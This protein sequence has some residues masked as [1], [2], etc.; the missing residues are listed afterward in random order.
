MKTW[1]SGGASSRVRPSARSM[2]SSNWPAG[3]TKGSP[4]RSSCSPGA[5][6][7][8][9]QCACGWPTPN[10]VC[11]RD[12]HSAQARHEATVS[13]KGA[14]R[15]CNAGPRCD[16]VRRAAAVGLCGAHASETA[17][18]LRLAVPADTAC[19]AEQAPTHR[20]Q[21][22]ALAVTPAPRGPHSSSAHHAASRK[23]PLPCIAAAPAD[24]AKPYWRRP[25]A[26]AGCSHALEPAQRPMH[27]V[28][29][30]VEQPRARPRAARRLTLKFAL[31]SST[32]LMA[33]SGRTDAVGVAHLRRDSR[34]P[35]NREFARSR[36]S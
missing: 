17:Q 26:R 7:T 16:R 32:P 18:A 15:A 13:R 20:L 27:S 1:R 33:T 5:S 6:P 28:A 8:I 3:P 2:L 4:W 24:W 11:W 34:R 22:A 9:I 19:R 31:I 30:T 35:R 21:Q 23:R 29:T 25:R 14:H 10:T 12:S 36:K